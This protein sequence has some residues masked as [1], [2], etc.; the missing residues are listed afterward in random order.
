M[1]LD[2]FLVENKFFDSRTKARQAI[3]RKE[4][5]LDGKAVEKAS[6]DVNDDTHKIEIFAEESFVSLGGYKLNKA[7]NDFSYSVNNLVVADIGASTGG[8]TDCLI[9]RGANKVFAVDLNDGLLHEKLRNNSKVVSVIKNAR[10]LERDDF[11]LPIDLIVADLS[12]I[13]ATY[14]LDVFSKLIRDD[15][16]VILL[17]KPQF[18]TGERIKF[19]NG[20]IRDS[21]IHQQVCEK[22]FSE[23]I[24]NNLIPIKFTCAPKNDNKNVEFLVLLEKNSKLQSIDAS[25][26]KY[27]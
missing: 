6:F 11:S 1:R 5:F 26:I 9:Q 4:V 3:D 22:I 23:C 17:I 24:K 13:S 7:L 8:F 15:K 12:F 27:S 2:V 18:E 16:H 19:K 20:I 14:V 10:Q 25:K 21:K